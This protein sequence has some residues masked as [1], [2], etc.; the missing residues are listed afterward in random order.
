VDKRTRVITVS[1]V[2]TALTVIFLHLA[3]ILPS[4]QFGAIAVS[5]LFT[6]AAVIETGAMSAVCVFAA[7]CALGTITVANKSIILLYALFFGY[8]PIAKCFAERLKPQAAVWTAKL[9]IFNAALAVFWFLLREALA[10]GGIA[11]WSAAIVFAAGNIA[12]A[13]FDIGLTKLIGLYI[14]R[15]AKR[16]PPP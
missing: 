4:G 9:A 5:S 11:K 1:A 13:L 3:A 14:H 7:G 10:A 2:L 12:F 15:I 16:R 6:A 8:Y